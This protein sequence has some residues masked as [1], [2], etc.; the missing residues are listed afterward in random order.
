VDGHLVAGDFN[1]ASDVFVRDL[2]VDA[3][4]LVS[5]AEATLPC[6]TPAQA[7]SVAANEH[8]DHDRLTDRPEYLAGADP[9][10]SASVLRALQVTPLGGGP[11]IIVW[12]AI[13]GREYRVQ[14]KNSVTA[15]NW[16]ELPFLVTATTTTRH[17][18]DNTASASEQRFYR[19]TLAP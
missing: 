8:T 6:L 4:R 5:V 13:P 11:K 3:T 7:S 18:I 1:R 17:F 12:S 19:V 2:D 10:N 15:S 9:T 14:F 16:S